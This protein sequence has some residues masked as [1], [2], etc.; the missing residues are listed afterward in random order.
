MIVIV[1]QT[2]L[3]LVIGISIIFYCLCSIYTIRF[4][5]SSVRSKDFSPPGGVSILI[6]VCGIDEGAKQNWASLCNQNYENYEVLFGVMSPED[7]ALPI[8]KEVVAEFPDRAKLFFGLEP[9]GINHQISNLS[10]LLEKAAHEIVIFADSDIRVTADYLSTVTAPLADPN[11]GVVTCG[12][13]ERTPK[14]LGAAVAALGRCTDFLP[15][16]LIARAI[17]H[18]LRFSLGPTIATRQSVLA[19]ING[20][21]NVVN[22]IGSDYHIGKM[23]SDAGY[24]VELSKYILNND[25]GRETLW[26][27][28]RRELRWARTIRI[29]RGWQYYTIGLSYGTIYCLPLLLLSGFQNWAII[30]SLITIILRA[31]QALI[32]IYNMRRPQLVW[33]LW[34]LPIRDLMNVIIW[35]GGAFGQSVYWR[36]RRLQIQPGGI[37][38]D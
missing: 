11:I 32:A 16:V 14:F 23:A 33:W 4:F 26:Q 5:S 35:V 2:F 17:D 8:L 21:Q 38:T 27:V 34:A 15:S 1:W 28:F 29:N 10:H 9:R 20:L 13:V 37:L 18:G 6:P 22:R 19:K 24:R 36:G 7:S 31:I 25:C 12:Y 30:L 3:L